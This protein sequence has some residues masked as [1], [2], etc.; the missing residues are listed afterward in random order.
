MRV[1][2]KEN[3]PA[4]V[5]AP[6]DPAHRERESTVDTARITHPVP[7]PNTR[8]LRALALVEDRFEEIAA[9]H[10]GGRYTVPASGGG[11]YSVTYT[12]CEESCECLGWQYG[13]TCYHVLAVCVVRAK[14]GVCCEC[15]RRARHRDLY[16][17]GD[18]HLTYF[19]GDQ[20]CEACAVG[21]G[22]L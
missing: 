22:I 1:S 7:R 13:H 5:G 6:R 2:R 4:G 18:D 21:A 11:T 19:E 12:A 15:G 16:P 8:E 17:V 20:L 14:T 10:R 9:S 3:G